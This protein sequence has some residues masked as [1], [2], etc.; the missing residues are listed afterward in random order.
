MVPLTTLTQP[1]NVVATLYPNQHLVWFELDWLMMTI[2][3]I[4]VFI[5]IAKFLDGKCSFSPL[6]V[7]Y[8]EKD[9]NDRED[10]FGVWDHGK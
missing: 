2:V 9:S 5:L 3:A 1:V 6:K 10:D 7:E 8:K 4:S